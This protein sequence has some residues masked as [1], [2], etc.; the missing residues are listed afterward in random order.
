MSDLSLIAFDLDG[1]LVNS[2]RD[3][4]DS[5]N[6]LLV[7]CGGSALSE[8]E[9]GKMVGEGAATLLARAFTAASLLA[10][11]DALARFLDLYDA[12]LLSHTRTYDGIEELLE[13]LRSRVRLGVLTNKPRK[14]TLR[15]LDGL[16][17][18]RFFD[19]A[20]TFSG[21]G[22]YPRKPDPRGLLGLADAAGVNAGGTMLVGDSIV[23][24]R[25][26]HAAG[27]RACVARYGFGFDSFAEEELAVDDWVIDSPADLEKFL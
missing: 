24:W 3:L 8:R 1:T 23:G 5:A 21:D 25:T 10:P 22:P 17:L 14:A 11:P 9:I 19:R 12:R 18:T 2:R 4:A 7:E 13:A 16:N 6:A 27:A 20:L 15:V 26:S